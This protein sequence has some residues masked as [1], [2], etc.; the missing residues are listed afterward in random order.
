M[1]DEHDRGVRLSD[2]RRLESTLVEHFERRLSEDGEKTRQH[3]AAELLSESEK[4]RQQVDAQILSEG[5]KTRRHADAR[6]LAGLEKTQQQFS[7][8]ILAEGEKTRRHF[9]VVAERVESLVKLVAEVNSH[10]AIV[11]DDHEHRL[12][13]IET[14]R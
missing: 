5:E 13:R 11:L 4:T 14:E 6:I 2:L 10:H 3:V 1:S 9:D 7:A 8:Q 12:K